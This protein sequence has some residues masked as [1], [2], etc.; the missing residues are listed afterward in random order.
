M[1]RIDIY[2]F[3]SG[4]PGGV[5]SVISNLLKFS[6]NPLVKNHVIKTINTDL[7]NEANVE[8]TV[9][10]ISEQVFYYSAN[11]NFYY[12]CRQLAKLLPNADAIIVAHDWLELGM[13]S[14]LGL[15]NPV[16]LFIHGD[17]NYYYQLAEKHEKIIDLF[18]PV[19]NNI[20]VKLKKLLPFRNDDISYLRFPVPPVFYNDHNKNGN[21]IFIGRCE[22]EKGYHLLPI[23]AK[24]IMDKG[25]NIHWHIAGNKNDQ[26]DNHNGWDEKIKVNFLGNIPNMELLKLL[27]G[28]QTIILPSIAEGMPVSL[29]E[30]M[31][32]GVIPVVNDIPGGI[33]ELII[34]DET[35]FKIKGNEVDGYVEKIIEVV[36]NDYTAKYIRQNCITVANKWF[37]PINNTNTIEEAFVTLNNAPRKLKLV[38]KAYGSRMDE[39]WIP[40]IITMLYRKYSRQ[41]GNVKHVSKR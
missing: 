16:I 36:N 13:M 23:I 11:W 38:N 6:N 22:I 37:D 4:R 34:D 24:K 33:Q 30:A 5:S 10:A 20:A 2:H 40:N 31:K 12:T 8:K 14:C 35:G 17:Y 28:M 19:A 26:G 39:P 21:V 25:I 32:A 18:I 7:Y 15:Q 29:I 9:G 3:H 1:N 27:P 41:P